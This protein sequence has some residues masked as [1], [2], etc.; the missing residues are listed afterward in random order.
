MDSS[1]AIT[2]LAISVVALLAPLVH[3][4]LE[5]R[6][7]HIREIEQFYLTRYWEL[8]DQAPVEALRGTDPA[9]PASHPQIDTHPV[10]IVDDQQGGEINVSRLAL[11]YQRMCDD[12]VRTRHRGM[13][14]DATWQE[15]LA[16]MQTQTARWPVADEWE[17]INA[18]SSEEGFAYLRRA[19][20]RNGSAYEQTDL[21]KLSGWVRYWRGLRLNPSRAPFDAPPA[22]K[23]GQWPDD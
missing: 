10:Q 9:N 13:I 5:G 22:Y 14:S 7:Q 3:G 8:Q 15:W 21:C 4:G 17:A 23:A 12:E 1:L 2:A 18:R 20:Q 6:R 19:L 16:A 11:L